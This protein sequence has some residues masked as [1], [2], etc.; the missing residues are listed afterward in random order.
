MNFL[1]KIFRGKKPEE[2]SKEP[3]DFLIIRDA[4]IENYVNSILE[5]EEV[6]VLK[7]VQGFVFMMSEKSSNF[8]K[9]LASLEQENILL[10]DKQVEKVVTS[11]RKEFLD[12][13]RRA[14][15]KVKNISMSSVEDF[16]NTYNNAL[17]A[18][19]E[20]NATSLKD[21]IA[22]K[23]YFLTSKDVL[24]NFKDLFNSFSTFQEKMKS[25]R[26]VNVVELKKALSDYVWVKS[27]I[28]SKRKEE[29]EIRNKIEDR[30][31][32]LENKK[33]ELIS[34]E[35]SE[36]M[37]KFF[38]L[39]KEKS[40]I[41]YREKELAS[42]CVEKISKVEYILKKVK[43]HLSSSNSK[44]FNVLSD[45]ISSPFDAAIH[46]DIQK[47]LKNVLDYMKNSNFNQE[48]ISKIEN[49]VNESF[50]SKLKEEYEKLERRLHEI[51]A[52]IERIDIIGRKVRIENEI[53]SLESEIFELEKR[54]KLSE[55]KIGELESIHS[56]VRESLETKISK[57]VGKEVKIIV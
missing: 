6:N 38:E 44:E 12:K 46:N 5:M 17:F 16:S 49:L 13:M 50:F 51:E 20:A 52:E 2:K 31:K 45:L 8:E 4:E 11:K 30:R 41:S 39:N 34:L 15:E 10:P 19:K 7:D 24:N 33:S 53:K 42:I 21:F 54:L 56:R 9:S 47:T 57:I 37:R 25:E 14:L 43:K 26:F 3:R 55:E 36:E 27:E 18:L 22:I 29:E 40:K 48:E 28:L 32:E 1:K 35:N 23:D